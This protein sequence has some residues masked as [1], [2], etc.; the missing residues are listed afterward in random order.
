MNYQLPRPPLS[1]QDNAIL[2]PHRPALRRM[3]RAFGEWY[4][5]EHLRD[6]SPNGVEWALDI[7][8]TRLEAPYQPTKGVDEPAFCAMMFLCGITLGMLAQFYGCTRQSVQQRV[9]RRLNSTERSVRDAAPQ[10]VDME[11]LVMAH[12]LFVKASHS[13]PSM[14]GSQRYTEDGRSLLSAAVAIISKDRGDAPIAHAI[15]RSDSTLNISQQASEIVARAHSLGFTDDDSMGDTL[16]TILPD[17]PRE[18]P[19]EPAPTAEPSPDAPTDKP[20]A[21]GDAALRELDKLFGV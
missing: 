6:L 14:F 10:D 7:V 13:N 3:T 1:A 17:A 15:A 5:S 21:L 9:A 11:V 8:G 18:E 2:F 20:G 4:I 19:T 16:S 12:E